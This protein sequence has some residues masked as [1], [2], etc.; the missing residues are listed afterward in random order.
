MKKHKLSII[1]F[2]ITI[3]I[4]LYFIISNNT[5]TNN[6]MSTIGN[7]ATDYIKGIDNAKSHLNEF[8]YN[9]KTNKVEYSPQKT[10]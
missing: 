5:K 6:A 2:I 10:N 4:I 3:A 1:I 8:T 7:S 9:S